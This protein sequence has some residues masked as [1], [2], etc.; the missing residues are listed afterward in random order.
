[1]HERWW[2]ALTALAAAAVVVLLPPAWARGRSARRIRSAADVPD[3]DVALVLG[4][5]VRRDG[6]PTPI[7]RGRLE[8][9]RELHRTGK[10]RRVLVS[11]SPSSRGHSEPLVMREHLVG[12][13]VPRAD[14]LLDESGVDTW[15]SCVFAARTFGRSRITVVTTNFHL[16]RAVSL[17]RRAGM[18]AYGVGHDAVADGLRR[19]AAKGSRRER[20]ATIKAFWARPFRRPDR[21]GLTGR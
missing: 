7:L 10:A 17:C 20:L 16:P 12:R 4:A 9:A 19:A 2:M 14:V 5:G 21:S 15:S 18:D 3:S 11:G 6:R 8:V 13:G 1:M